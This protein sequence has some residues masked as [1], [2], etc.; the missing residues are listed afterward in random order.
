MTKSQIQKRIL[1]NGKPL[2]IDK[3]EWDETTRTF[4][5]NEHNLVLDFRGM[6]G[7]IFVMGACYTF[8]TGAGCTFVVNNYSFPVPP[9]RGRK[10]TVKYDE[11]PNSKKN[12]T[13]WKTT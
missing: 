11:K 3:F 2:E 9:M 13:K 5:S 1:Q 7:C 10:W 4:R 6:F 8:V 12:I